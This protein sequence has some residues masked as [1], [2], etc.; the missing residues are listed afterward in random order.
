LELLDLSHNILTGSIPR[1]IAELHNLQFYLNLSWNF[2]EGSLPL[3]IGKIT[4]AQAIDV[5][6]NHLTGA[7]PSTIGSCVEL[8][9]LNLSQNSFQGSIPDS[10]ENLKSLM[11]L[12]LSSNSLSGIIP[13]T[14]NNL[15]MLQYLNLSFNKLTGEIP[16]GGPFANLSISISLNGNP[17]LCGP[18]VFQLS[19]CPRPRG[20]PTIVKRVL[21]PISGT[22]LFSFD[23][24]M[25]KE[26]AYTKYL[27]LKCY[28]PKVWASKDL[29]SRAS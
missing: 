24:P 26:Y 21:F 6:A 4:M 5:S 11:S 7:I 10:L 19:A 8:F 27:C 15:E 23:I 2:L 16:R 25:A 13:P 28:F 29:I 12:D 1:E 9:S 22:M 3:E 17:N 14:L 18:Q 20:H